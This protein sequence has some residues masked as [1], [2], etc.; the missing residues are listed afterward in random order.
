[1]RWHDADWI[2]SD[3]RD[4]DL[5]DGF[6]LDGALALCQDATGDVS[7][8]TGLPA[9]LELAITDGHHGRATCCAWSPDGRRL[10][11]GSYDNTLR[12][13]DA[14]SG[15]MLLTCVLTGPGEEAAVDFASNRVLWASPGAWRY[16]GWRVRDPQTD[17]LR[18]LPAEFLGPLPG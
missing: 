7:R 5:G 18:I 9:E 13:W 2:R 16:L 12:V 3:L 4:A 17:R 1:V 8:P 6:E 10:L 14:E 11:S 15:R